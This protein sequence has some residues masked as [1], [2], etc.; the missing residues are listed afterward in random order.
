MLHQQNRIN[1]LRKI[2]CSKWL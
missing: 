1:A 2:C